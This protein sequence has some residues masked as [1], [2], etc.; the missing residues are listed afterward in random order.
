M[1]RAPEVSIAARPGS[2]RF[3]PRRAAAPL[4]HRA[5]LR[6]NRGSALFLLL[7]LSVVMA[8]V[9]AGIFTYI[10]A[11]A[12]TEKR[13]NIRLESAYTA[14]YAFE[15]A[16]QRLYS[17]VMQSSITLPDVTKTSAVT[18][19]TTAP[20]DV[21]SAANGY[22]WKAFVTLPV[23]DGLPAASPPD[24]SASQGQYK[25]MTIVEFTRKVPPMD[26]PVHMQFQR[27]W[28]FSL[29]PLFQYAIFYNSDLELF[30][31]A[32]FTVGGRVHSNGHIYT[33]STAS[34][35]YTDY[36]TDVNGASNHYHS[37]ADP[38][39]EP[40]LNAPTYQKAQPI[41]SSQQNPP[42]QFNSDT[43]DTNHNND[44]PHELI[45]VPNTW[46]TDDNASDRMYNKAGV[47]I[48]ANSGATDVTADNG[49]TISAG[50]GAVLTKD[51]SVIGF[52]KLSN[53]SSTEPLA[54]YIGSLLNES[55][56]RDYR[57]AATLTTTEVDVGAL[58]TAYN[59]GYLSQAVPTGWSNGASVPAILRGK[60]APASVVGKDFWNGVLY[61]TDVAN[62]TTHRTGIVLKNGSN[63]PDGTK[64]AG[65]VA[66]LT[67]VTENAAYIKGDYNTG[68]STAPSDTGAATDNNYA[69]GYTVQPAAV[70]AD[71]VTVVSSNF[72]T[73]TGGYDSSTALSSRPATN[74]TINTALVSG[75]VAS[76][77]TAYSGGAENYIR[78][79][80]NWSSK[81]LTYYGS[82]INVYQSQE[83]TA[84]WPGTGVV[85]NAPTRNWYFDVN[86]LDPNKLPP[87]T[88]VLRSLL[89][90]QWVQVE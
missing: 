13:S 6:G 46:Q 57:E 1:N 68:G 4:A 87:G 60:S 67:V 43:T 20:T 33:G 15:L 30:P 54:Q 11:T 62:S 64:T 50:Y 31:G 80:E 89:R 21:F 82:M 74:T 83:S 86:F 66:G 79:L 12:K 56:L 90:G 38:R 88:P 63:L 73:G 42:G 58:N 28:S 78:L 16:Y 14:E 8:T 19:L 22:A 3:Q 44:G 9:L 27:E 25:F 51:G 41:V 26:E 61:I 29:T 34:I 37:P 45:E 77:G 2:G 71:A 85:Y 72:A 70:M 39:T 23:V 49:V 52:V 40:T 48:L 53:M 24:L 5:E 55:T 35:T 47:K 32:A 10:S 75:V 84:H 7:I 81:R 76:D 18:N 69:S 65:D 59:G 17:Q 36:V